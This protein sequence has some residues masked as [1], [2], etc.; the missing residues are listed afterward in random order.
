MSEERV[1]L[2]WIFVR[3]VRYRPGLF[4]LNVLVFAVVHSWPLLTGLLLRS[5]FNTVSGQAPAGLNVWT[6]LALLLGVYVVFVG[7]RATGHWI[8]FTLEL[9][10]N[11]LL[12]RNSIEW[13]CQGPGSRNLPRSPG[14]AVSRLRGDVRE[15]VAF[16]ANWIDLAGRLVFTLVAIGIMYTIEPRVTAAMLIPLVLITLFV[17]SMTNRIRTYR[18][19]RRKAAGRV[20]GFIA[21]MF[22]AVQAVKVTDMEPHVLRRFSELN[23]DRRKA[24][25][26]D[27]LLSQLILSVYTNMVI[28]A[29]GIILLMVAGGMRRQEFTVGDFSLFVAYLPEISTAMSF[30]GN[31]LAQ[32]RRVGVSFDRLRELNIGL[33]RAKIT[34]RNP[35]HLDGFFPGIPPTERKEKDTLR[36]MRVEGLTFRYPASKRGIESIDLTLQKGSLTVVT[37]RIGS[38]KTTL[39]R[40]ILGLVTPQAGAIFWNDQRIDDPGLMMVPPRCAYTPQVPRLFSDRLRENILMG[41]PDE[42]GALE[43]AVRLAVLDR[44]MTELEEGLDTLVGPRGVK[45]SGGQMQRSAAGRMFMR[46]AELNLIDDLS[47]ALDVETEQKLWQGLFANGGMTC[48]VA[49]HRQV[50]LQRADQ[51]VV[52]KEGRVEAVGTLRE[53][54]QSCEEM[55]HLWTESE[56]QV[57]AA[58]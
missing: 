51:I 15:L 28:I 29:S 54:L 34:K 40:A 45:L 30:F 27:T 22:G 12:R 16:I 31:F 17:Q 10:L 6:L 5:I 52:L 3:M 39:L 58:G 19:A 11:A 4:A 24:A 55:K 1:S 49:T 21:E 26:K 14:E 47:S 25:L 8:W 48:L 23:E 44:D 35:L 18:R 46:K 38:G 2:S 53:L 9:S 43:E 37:G 42:D 56:S 13:L 36:E 50:A 20:T 33:P 7:Q 57:P 32:L 41:M